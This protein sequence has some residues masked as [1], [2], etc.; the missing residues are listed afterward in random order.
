ML[1]RRR[2]PDPHRTIRIV[3]IF[4]GTM[5]AARQPR[6]YGQALVLALALVGAGCAFL[7][8][9]RLAAEP[10]EVNSHTG[11]AISGFDPV[12]YFIDGKP[13]LGRP[14]LELNLS[15][16]IWQFRNEGNR[17][18]FAAHPEVYRPRFGGY[19]PVAVAHGESVPG[20]PLIW[21]LLEER[22]YLFYDAKAR[23]TFL[24]DPG[25]ILVAAERKWPMIAKGLGQ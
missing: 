22:L 19:D 18:A 16:A 8:V 23:A 5:T 9:S 14:G 6:K 4:S 7:S 20:H 12:T 1:M 13:K 15:G 24:A 2:Y 21:A 10:I 25:R 17:A 11:L 3:A